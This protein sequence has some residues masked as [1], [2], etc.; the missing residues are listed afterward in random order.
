MSGT[1]IAAVWPLAPRIVA[2]VLGLPFAQYRPA[3]TGAA[4]AAGNL[5]GM[6]PAW[7]TA[8]AKLMADKPFAYGKPVGFASV[9]PALTMAGD[10]LVGSLTLAGTPD[11]FFIAS[12]DIPAPIQVVIC[13]QVLT[14]AR[15]IDETPGAGAYGGAKRTSGAPLVTSWPASVIQGKNPAPGE[16]R[17]PGDTKLPWVAI[18][19]PPPGQF[20]GVPELRMGDVIR[21]AQAEPNIYTV[22]DAELTPLGWRLSAWMASA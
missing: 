19:L 6:I 22:A 9:D 12:Q 18:L 15:P 20:G 17:N 10:Y 21:D 16:L 5:L 7:I 3:G 8:D 11:T 4:I 13:N 14:I 1:A 2:Q